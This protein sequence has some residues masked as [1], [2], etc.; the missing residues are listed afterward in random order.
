MD[1][2]G[3]LYPR[4]ERAVPSMIFFVT[5]NKQMFSLALKNAI[6][7]VLIILIVHF[8]IK[9]FLAHRQ[10]FTLALP[11]S[12]VQSEQLPYQNQNQ[13]QNQ[14]YS[15]QIS[16]EAP[17][18]QLQPQLAP[19]QNQYQ[20]DEEDLYK[21]IQKNKSLNPIEHSANVLAQTQA[22]PGSFPLEQFSLG[23]F[24]SFKGSD[25]GSPFLP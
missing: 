8:L 18:S 4:D 22:T 15:P 24:S 16:Q 17:Q 2:L 7:M 19:N 3:M 23:T 11:Q 21:F 5:I 12:L 1:D 13:N 6:L 9:N 25:F 10:H 20:K 14:L